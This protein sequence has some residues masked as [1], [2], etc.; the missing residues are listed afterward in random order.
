MVVFL[1]FSFNVFWNDKTE[2][3]LSKDSGFGFQ[4]KL[5]KYVKGIISLN[6]LENGGFNHLEDYKI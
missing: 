2:E 5:T 1:I 4:L 6:N 3:P